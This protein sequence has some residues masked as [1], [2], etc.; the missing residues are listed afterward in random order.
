MAR[1]SII[2]E[3]GIALFIY[4]TLLSINSL[5][6]NAQG[7]ES[8]SSFN[9]SIKLN[10][11]YS[12]TLFLFWGEASDFLFM[13]SQKNKIFSL[14]NERGIYNFSLN[15]RNIKD[16]VFYLAKKNSTEEA[17]GVYS[18]TN[19]TDE[20]YFEL[21]DNVEMF[22]EENRLR[23]SGKD[24]FKFQLQYLL[25]TACYTT[26]WK[27]ELLSCFDTCILSDPQADR[28]LKVLPILESNRSLIDSKTFNNLKASYIYRSSRERFFSIREEL[29]SSSLSTDQKIKVLDE[30]KNR[31]LNWQIPNHV[32]IENVEYVKFIL[33]ELM[34]RYELQ[35]L[36]GSN[37]SRL[38]AISKS[39]PIDIFDSLLGAYI[40]NF[41]LST[42]EIAP[43]KEMYEKIDNNVIKEQIKKFTNRIPGMDAFK[44]ELSDSNNLI[45]KLA[46][47]K[48]RVIV[49]DFWFTG[50]MNCSIYKDSV[51]IPLEKFFKHASDVAFVSISVDRDISYW[52]AS[53][54]TGLYTTDNSIK[55]Y[56]KGQA[57]N[58]DL[59]K[60]Y[61]ISRYPFIIVIDKDGKIVSVN[62]E[63]VKNVKSLALMIQQSLAVGKRHD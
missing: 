59:I 3:K 33:Y 50:C 55:L 13:S 32:L 28:I 46:D 44:F 63:E 42:E 4:I 36:G 40:A 26:R 61:F 54:K 17:K 25:H 53:I 34:L 5:Q 20:Y 60:N 10:E 48:G 15:G 12:D 11:E 31:M 8:D 6:L 58:N 22:H 35:D 18:E 37:G 52:K 14:K 24:Y 23:F 45:V 57:S 47:F 9:L 56:T 21:G 43:F 41:S 2:F 16:G 1:M 30:Y 19:I 29:L 7:N 38:A 62:S 39:F 49:L 27:T 51:L